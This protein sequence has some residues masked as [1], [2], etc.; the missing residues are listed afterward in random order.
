MRICKPLVALAA[1][2]L[3]AALSIGGCAATSTSPS[4]QT[5]SS[6]SASVSQHKQATNEFIAMLDADP[7]LKALMEKSI[8]KAAK[9]NPD[10]TTNPAQ[11]LD[12]F[13][14]FIDWSTTCEPWGVLEGAEYPTL[15]NEID[16]SIDYLWFILDQPLEELENQGYYYPTLQYREPIS[17]W[18]KKY[19]D[20]WGEFLNS[21]ESWSNE[22]YEKAKTDDHFGLNKGWYGD[23]NIWT[24]FNDFFARRLADPSARPI[25]QSDVVAPADSV[26]QGVWN[27]SDDGQLEEHEGVVIKSARFT[28]IADL[29][30]PDSAYTKSFDAGT[31]THTFLDVNDY[32]RYHF[33]VSGTIV[34]VRK[35]PGISAAGGITVWDAEEGRYRLEAQNPGWQ[36]IET[37]SCVIVDTDEFGLVAVLPVGMSQVSSCNWEDSVKVGARVEKG[38]PMGYFLFGGSDIIM[39]FQKQVS[40]SMLAPGSN[41]KYEHALM[42]EAYADLSVK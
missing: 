35:I 8:E 18:L 10:R 19:S 39:L 40:V 15:Y 23:K 2:L 22:Y 38:D 7:E 41:G 25:A 11:T 29:I 32:H 28:S 3:V 6:T 27:I 20:T 30:G 31:M 36:M 26:P 5:S 9:I 37:R 17:S 24:S 12:E 42:G 21:P 34:E 14:D 13:Y 33:P 16:Q 4:Q 1:T